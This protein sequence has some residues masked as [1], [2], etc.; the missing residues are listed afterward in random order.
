MRKHLIVFIALFTLSGCLYETMY[1]NADRLALNR[2]EDIVELS[3]EQEEYFLMSFNAFQLVHQKEYMP[4]YL[5]WLKMLKSEWLLLDES[6]LKQLADEVQTHW[7]EVTER[8]NKPT[9]ALLLGF[10]KQQKQQLM[11]TLKE[12]AQSRAKNRDRLER[13]IERFEDILGDL[14]PKQRGIITNYLDETEYN[15]EVWNLHTQSRLKN[16]DS[17]LVLKTPLKQAERQLMARSVFNSMHGA[18]SHLKRIRSQWVNKQIKLL[19]NMRETLS[20]SQKQHVDGF[21]QNWIDV[22]D[23]L[24]KAQL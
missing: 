21:L 10:D 19:I 12:R 9:M 6:Q 22:V 7:F 15:R 13:V 1:K 5:K 17:V 18:P 23:E 2:L 16:F 3:D 11:S 20:P 4:E 24:S 14:S 8:I